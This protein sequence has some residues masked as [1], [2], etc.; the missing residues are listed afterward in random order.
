MHRSLNATRFTAHL[1]ATGI[2]LTAAQVDAAIIAATS[3]WNGPVTTDEV[4]RQSRALEEYL[5]TLNLHCKH[6]KR[7]EALARLHGARNWHAI[8]TA[9]APTA[10]PDRPLLDVMM[11]VQGLTAQQAEVA[12]AYPES[13]IQDDLRAYGLTHWAYIITLDTT[14]SDLV[15]AS[16]TGLP[17]DTP[18]DEVSDY[19]DYILPDASPDWGPEQLQ[20]DVMQ[21]I[22]DVRAHAQQ[23]SAP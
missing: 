20:G 2:Y 21:A 15:R 8:H 11:G 4:K 16:T 5:R 23:A 18:D 6:L 19:V 22:L 17:L 14:P 13:R 3:N 1:R 9:I 7:L 12:R 10:Q